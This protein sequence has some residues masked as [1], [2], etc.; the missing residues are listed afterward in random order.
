MARRLFLHIGPP[1]TG[2]TF[3]QA[4][5]FQHRDDLAEQGILYPG[6]KALDQFRAAAVLLDKQFVVKRL[7]GEQMTAADR[8]TEAVAAWEGDAIISSEHY[9]LAAPEQVPGV[10]HRYSSSAEELHLVVTVRDLARQMPAAWQQGIKTGRDETFDDFWRSLAADPKRFFWVA[11]D[12]P[13]LLTRWTET[14]SPDRVHLVV[15]GPPGS[16]K[17][18][19][20]DEVCQV[21][22]VDPDVLQPVRNANESLGVVPTEFLRRVNARLPADRDRI[23]MDR[24]TKTFIAKHVL[25]P[26]GSQVPLRLPEEAWSWAVRRSE[27]VVEELER[28]GYHVVGNLDDLVPARESSSG[29]T[30]GS[31]SDEEIAELGVEVFAQV[32]VE[33]TQDAHLAQRQRR[34]RRL[35]RKRDASR[36][37]PTGSLTDR[38][39]G[40]LRRETE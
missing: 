22:G 5:W 29:R 17:R 24:L 39:R 8:L 26:A 11:Q 15:H 35:M 16:A 34:A 12:L 14:L 4:A 18:L 1:K 19:L 23:G 27:A 10:L 37:E 7:T 32:M 33:L 20:W 25:S 40:L 6:D 21:T 30:P 2:T 9:S 13:A 38:V 28:R 31:V 36:T 3:L